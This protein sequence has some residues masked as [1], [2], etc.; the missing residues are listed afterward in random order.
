MSYPGNIESRRK[1]INAERDT[2]PKTK[3]MMAVIIGFL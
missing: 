3:T 1:K 2:K